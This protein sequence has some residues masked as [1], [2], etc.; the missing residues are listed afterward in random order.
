MIDYKNYKISENLVPVLQREPIVSLAKLLDSF[1][2]KYID[3]DVL[4]LWA[5]IDVMKPDLLDHLAYQLHVDSYEATDSIEVKR[6]LIKQSIA[7]HKHKGTVFAVKTAIA[8]VFEQANLNEWFEYGGEPYHF[9]VDEITAP[10]RGDKDVTRLVNLINE[11]KN[12]RSW[13][14]EVSFARTIT[15]TE[16]IGGAVAVSKQ[17][18]IESDF[19]TELVFNTD[20]HI[21]AGLAVGKSIE[22]NTTV[23]NEV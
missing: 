10:L 8:A 22:I 19:T 14:E 20:L 11:S 3:L 15:G 12:V 5:N 1:I 17:I 2:C 9:K 23:N 4:L 16:F 21:N 7:I 6:Q 18:T 13:L